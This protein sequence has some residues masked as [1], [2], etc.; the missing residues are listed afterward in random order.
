[1]TSNIDF[2]IGPIFFENIY[3]N[4]YIPLNKIKIKYLN[5]NYVFNSKSLNIMNI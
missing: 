2:G 1:M 4:N 3:N 5:E